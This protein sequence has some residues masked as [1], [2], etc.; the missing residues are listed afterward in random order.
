MERILKDKRYK[1][2]GNSQEQR[3]GCLLQRLVLIKRC[4]QILLLSEMKYQCKY[5][6]RIRIERVYIVNASLK[7]AWQMI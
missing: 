5:T 6:E 1:L 7:S 4:N 3:V 2:E